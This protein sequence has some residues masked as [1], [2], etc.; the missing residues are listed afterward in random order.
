MP[1]EINTT[2]KIQNW[3]EKPFAEYENGRKLTRASITTKYEGGLEGKGLLE[4]VMAYDSAGNATFVGYERIE[5]KIGDKTGSFVF[6]HAGAFK[7]GVAKSKWTIA[8]GMG[9]GDFKN[10]RGEYEF[11][12]G[13]QP[14]F[15]LTLQLELS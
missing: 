4:Y 7:D 2:L 9:T 14:E 3:E 11:E 13:H 8:E 10:L 15:Q 1:T 6:H 12:G 5:G